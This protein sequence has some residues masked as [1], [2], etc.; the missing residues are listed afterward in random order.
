MFSAGMKIQETNTYTYI[1][2]Q[3]KITFDLL[4]FL[5]LSVHVFCLAEKNKHCREQVA[6][7]TANRMK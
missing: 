2:S 5:K 1:F 3:E 7:Q 4:N 6:E